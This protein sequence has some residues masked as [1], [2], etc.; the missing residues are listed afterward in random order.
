MSKSDPIPPETHL[1]LNKLHDE[2]AQLRLK[3]AAALVQ[4]RTNL[5]NLGLLK[6]AKEA[7]NREY[8]EAYKALGLNRQKEW[9]RYRISQGM[10]RLCGEPVVNGTRHCLKH[11]EMYE[12]RR[13]AK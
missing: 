6:G 2:A 5:A 4:H 10:C 1:A 9:Q 7:K 13:V 8:R 12:K 11:E 3:H